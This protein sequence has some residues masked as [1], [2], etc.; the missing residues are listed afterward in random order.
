MVA[1]SKMTPLQTSRWLLCLVVSICVQ[2]RLLLA[3]QA[4]LAVLPALWPTANA[5]V[6]LEVLPPHPKTRVETF[7]LGYHAARYAAASCSPNAGAGD[8]D[9]YLSGSCATIVKEAGSS[10]GRSDLTGAQ[11]SRARTLL[12]QMDEER[13]VVDRI[14]GLFSFVNIVWTVAIVGLVATVGPFLAYI[15]GEQLVRIAKALYEN[16]ILPTHRVGGLEVLAYALSI[17]L[18]AQSYRYPPQQASAATMVALSGAL[19][20]GP[21]WAYSTALH[22]TGP[23]DKDKFLMVTGA[24]LALAFAPLALAHQSQVIGFATLGAAYMALGFVMGAFFGGFYVG[25]DGKDALIRSVV[26]SAVL[27]VVFAALRICNADAWALRPFGSAVMVLGNVVYFL[28]M[29]IM[30]S[31]YGE[32]DFRI[33]NIAMLVS[34]V[35]VAL[36]GS[37]FVLPAATNTACVFFVLWAMEKEMEVKWGAAA[38]AVLFVN[39]IGLYF[40]AHYLHTHPQ[41][42]GSLFDPSGMYV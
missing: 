18:A 36:I 28:G 6:A 37:V 8:L 40:A 9:G 30:S 33:T 11:L 7:D 17:C 10:L 31:R 5:S 19:A 42:I 35:V 32:Y 15:F 38:I 25:F 41:V 24:L 21:C 14:A 29:L 12:Q 20:L 1:N 3:P 27:V 22:A 4:V 39:F 13:S 34:L 23:G 2:W 26:A 16:V